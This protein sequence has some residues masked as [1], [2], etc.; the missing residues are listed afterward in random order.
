VIKAGMVV[1]DVGAN[2]GIYTLTASRLLGPRGRVHAFEPAKWA[3]RQLER[4]V[5]LNSCSNVVLNSIGLSDVS[6]TVTFNICED[7]AYNSLAAQ[8]MMPV[9]KSEKITVSTI[10]DYVQRNG[11]LGVHVIKIDA[12]GADYL[13]LKGARNTLERFSPILFFEYN[14]FVK[15]LSFSLADLEDYLATMDYELYFV[16]GEKLTSFS[17][18]TSDA[19]EIVALK[20]TSL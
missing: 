4:N 11:L 10:D 1:F 19:I 5:G 6:G 2:I 3:F 9:L 7:D 8:P 18:E 12:E 15:G 13:I 20:E 14:R 17:R 16:A